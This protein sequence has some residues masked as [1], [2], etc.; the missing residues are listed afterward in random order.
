MS[1]AGPPEAVSE[2]QPPMLTGPDLPNPALKPRRWGFGAYLLAEAVFL[3]VSVLL[4][5]PYR[6]GGHR[7]PP[8]VLL[9]SVTVPTVM[10]ALVAVLATVLRGNGPRIDLGLRFNRA[11]I[12]R[13]LTYGFGGL[14]LTIPAAAIW[15][16]IVGPSKANAAVAELFAGQRFPPALAIGVFLV[17]WL[18]AP[19][20]EE[21][22]Y[23]G[24]LWGAMERH[25][26]ARWWAF[27][28]T[29]LCFALAH[30]EFTRTP[31]L[32]VIAVPIGL[33]RLFTG[34]LLASII[35]HQLN[36]LLPA[37]SLLLVLLGVLK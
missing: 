21:I 31:L 18:V 11:D 15:T 7:A 36:N 23:R 30:F 35:A 28:L 9:L 26:A 16:R 19:I 33:A 34:R 32:I 5:W 17:V 6:H 14:V 2:P 37:V 22:V 24:L 4:V 29:T 1:T 8:E 10:A 3:S 27:G 20:C 13:G 25:G 12:E